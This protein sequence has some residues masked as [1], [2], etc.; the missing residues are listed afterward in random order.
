[1][2]RVNLNLHLH[3][4]SPTLTPSSGG[5]AGLR[6]QSA[7]GPQPALVLGLDRSCAL[8]TRCL[9]LSLAFSREK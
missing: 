6:V 9:A 4:G 7:L 1:M 2:R 5:T 8:P 3:L